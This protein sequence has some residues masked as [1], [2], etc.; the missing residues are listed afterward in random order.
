MSSQKFD[1]DATCLSA[2]AQNVQS[3]MIGRLLAGIGIGISSAVVPLYISEV[4]NLYVHE[5]VEYP[6]GYCSFDAKTFADG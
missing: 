1:I 5:V 2:T 3:M 4:A 6:Y